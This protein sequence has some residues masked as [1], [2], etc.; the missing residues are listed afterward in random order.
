MRTGYFKDAFHEYLIHGNHAAVNP[1]H[2]GTKA[3][4]G[5]I[6]HFD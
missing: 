6:A 5:I 4:C 1:A 2:T 3:A